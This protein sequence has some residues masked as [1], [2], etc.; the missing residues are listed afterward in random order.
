MIRLAYKRLIAALLPLS[1]MLTVAACV[2]N[3]ERES[4][5]THRH[6]AYS[7][8]LT[9][10]RDLPDCGGCPLTSFPKATTPERETYIQGLEPVSSLF[11]GPI[12]YSNHNTSKG[13]LAI[14]LSSDSPP[15]DPLPTIR[16]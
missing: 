12:H 13:W 9:G 11:V 7:S 14:S 5:I 10:I 6:T 4:S 16:I 8:G 15:L 1:F 2:S 3:C